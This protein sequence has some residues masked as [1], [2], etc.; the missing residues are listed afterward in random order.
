MGDENPIRILGDYSKPRHEGYRNTIKLIGHHDTQY[1]MED[2]EQAFVEYTSSCTDKAGGALPSDTIKN[3]KLSTSPVL[4]GHSY[5]TMDAHCSTPSQL[6]LRNKAIPMMK[7]QKRMR[8]KKRITWKISMSTPPY[9]LIY[10]LHF[11]PKKSSNSIHSSNCSDWFRN[12][13]KPRLYLTRRSLEVLKNFHWMIL[14]GRSNQL[15]LVSS[16]LLSKPGEY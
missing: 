8:K 6:N 4:P 16:P 2:P 3:P 7:K 12:H 11:S 14:G 9:R 1:C 10:Q 5:P 13:L 15:S